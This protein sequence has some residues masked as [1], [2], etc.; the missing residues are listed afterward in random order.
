[1]TIVDL[2]CD[3]GKTTFTVDTEKIQVKAF[4]HCESCQRV[5]TGPMVEVIVV[6]PDA[7]TMVD[8][9]ELKEFDMDGKKMTRKFCGYVAIVLLLLLFDFLSVPLT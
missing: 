6:T 7:I 9:D 3:C 8:G 5:A 1:M 2:K 4:C